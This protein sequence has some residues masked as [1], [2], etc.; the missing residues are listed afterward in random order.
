MSKSIRKP[1]P[2]GDGICEVELT[3]G[4]VAMIDEADADRVSVCEWYAH[5]SKPGLVYAKARMPGGGKKIPMHRL[6]LCFPI[7]L[8]DHK[9]GDTLDNRRLNLRLVT[10]GQNIRNMTRVRGRVPFKG[11]YESGK[12]FS[13]SIY[14]ANRRQHLGTFDTQL[15]AALAYDAAAIRYFGEF[16]ATNE[17][18]GL[19]TQ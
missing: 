9:N 5:I 13:S 19:L 17:S 6:I 11:V 8:V 18:L 2:I 10:N 14:A 7:L 1:R 12:R 15:E 16:A 3:R 4:F